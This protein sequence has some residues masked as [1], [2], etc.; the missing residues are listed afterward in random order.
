MNG[1]DIISQSFVYSF[2]QLCY[3]KL[4]SIGAAKS[5]DFVILACT[6]LIQIARVWRTGGRTDRRLDDG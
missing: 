4:E 3:D 1:D 2:T 6:V 5:E